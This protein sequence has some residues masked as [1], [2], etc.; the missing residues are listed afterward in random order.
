MQILRFFFAVWPSG[1]SDWSHLRHAVCRLAVY[2]PQE[3]FSHSPVGGSLIVIMF[4][5]SV[6]EI[7]SQVLQISNLLAQQASDKDGGSC[8]GQSYSAPNGCW[9][10]LDGEQF[11]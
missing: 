2:A 3:L 11:Y 9:L 1:F 7:R 6:L 10:W 5:G 4:E 8:A